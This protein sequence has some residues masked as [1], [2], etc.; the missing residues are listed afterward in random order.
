MNLIDYQTNEASESRIE[1]LLQKMSLNEK[2]SLLSGKDNW[3]TV[4]VERIGIPSLVMTDGPHGVR[5][6]EGE[7]RPAVPATSFPTGISIASSWNP[8]LIE[9]VGIAL[10]QETRAMGCDILLGPTVNIVRSPLAGRNF[11]TYSED[12]YLAGRIGVAFV[13]GVQSYRVGAS[14]KHF[15]CNNQETER[16]RGSSVVDERT[17]REIYLPAF[18]AVVKEAKP[19]T[20]MCS[21]NRINGTYASEN[22]FLLTEI[23]KKEWD[24]DGVVIS[25]WGA[26]HSIA[27]SVNAGL[28]IEMPGPARYY[29][30]Y[31]AH[32][33]QMW[34]VE[35]AVVDEAVR[36]ILRMIF[37]AGKFNSHVTIQLGSI[38]TTEHQALARLLAEESIV[39][40][41]ND[42]RLLPLDLARI[43]SIAVI[44]PNAAE[45]RISGGGSS[46]LVPPY[47]IGPIEGLR[48]LL[49]PDVKI[50][51]AQGCLKTVDA[52]QNKKYSD[53]LLTY[54]VEL[55]KKCDVAVLF[56]GMPVGYE[57]EG[58]DRPDMNLPG[59]QDELIQA[60]AGAN[61][62]TI[63]ILNAG[64]PVAM[65][66]IDQVPAVLDAFYP[67]Q[68]GG[69]AIARVLAG[70]VN[71]SGK[72]SVTFPKTLEDNPAYINF[73]GNR[74]VLY[75]EGIFV[76]YRYYDQKNI[77]PLFPF[78]AGLSYTTFE[79]SQLELPESALVG[80]P[81]QVSIK[82]K[83]CGDR[84]GKEVIQLYVGDLKSSLARPPQELKAFKKITLRAGESQLV[85]FDLDQRAFAFYH[86]VQRQWVVEPGSFEI[87]VGSSSRD[88]RSRGLLSLT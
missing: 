54:A 80:D 52:N 23:L 31:L 43:Q 77:E 27:E 60:V 71:P 53:D 78:G 22:G 69:M 13:K 17:L 56:V 25:D 83:N 26:N 9:Q 64:S 79:Y 24:F 2:I 14:V 87:L 34:Q 75:G 85:H 82:V 33:V 4:P 35:E 57:S 49:S 40:L 66:W 11:E 30:D 37:K 32:A 84:D 6:P 88:I 15:A 44:G 58:F 46:C 51:Y 61:R 3:H 55:A 70:E 76:G 42:R 8:E 74:E 48:S 16:R 86:P 7:N 1:E 41:K 47:A 38:N 29:G 28:D 62:N 73:P 81:V 5:A 59:R 36:R 39:L 20:V 67:G 68:E 12:P 45:A 10:A 72:L 18:E 21:Y 19:W 63:V 65:P 50:E